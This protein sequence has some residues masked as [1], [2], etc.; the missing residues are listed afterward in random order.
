M[1]TYR[2]GAAVITLALMTVTAGCTSLL[3]D[4]TG[5]GADHDAGVVVEHDAG[6]GS[7]SGSSSGG[8]SSGSS[9]GTDASSGAM[10]AAADAMDSAPPPPVPGKPGF[11]FTAGGNTSVSENYKLIGAVG[12]APGSNVVGRSTNYTLKGGVVAGTQ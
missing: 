3:G 8:S 12:E 6:S 10:D 2:S 5:G 11:D 4:F 7:S 1:P 9:S